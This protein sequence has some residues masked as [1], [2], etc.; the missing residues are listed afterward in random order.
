M[1]MTIILKRKH[2]N[3]ISKVDRLA[4][5][6]IDKAV[7]LLGMTFM[8]GFAILAVVAIILFLIEGDIM[9]IVGAVTSGLMSWMFWSA[10]KVL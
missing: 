8:I 4:A 7:A 1:Q 9:N 6:I 10:K 2:M 3:E 5:D